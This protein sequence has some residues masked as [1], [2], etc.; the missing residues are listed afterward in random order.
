[1]W[2]VGETSRDGDLI[3]NL[4]DPE[5]DE[6]GGRG[7][8]GDDDDDDDEGGGGGS[9]GSSEPVPPLMG[10]YDLVEMADEDT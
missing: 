5:A 4:V 6:E 2:V 3:L 1:M 10:L 8:D 7:G 9:S